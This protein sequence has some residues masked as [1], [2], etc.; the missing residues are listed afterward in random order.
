MESLASL[1]E[2]VPNSAFCQRPRFS[3]RV[4]SV[5]SR[6]NIARQSDDPSDT[7]TTL[8]HTQVINGV[9]ADVTND[10][11]STLG[12]VFRS[13]PGTRC[14]RGRSG[15]YADPKAPDAPMETGDFQEN[16]KEKYTQCALAP[17]IV[18]NE[19]LSYIMRVVLDPSRYPLILTGRSFE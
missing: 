7:A 9:I 16:M 17:K 13:G 11:A 6:G 19:T 10:E 4:F 15:L 1:P 5:R 8:S 18:R 3:S 12:K 14:T 2:E